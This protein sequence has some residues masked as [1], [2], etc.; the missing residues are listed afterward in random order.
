MPGPSRADVDAAA[1]MSGQDRQAMIEGMVAQLAARL[2]ASGGD[3]EEWLRLIR[4]YQVLGRTDD[5]KAAAE[6]ALDAFS[7]DPEAQARIRSIEAEIG[8]NQ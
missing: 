5:A 1:G 7:G 3:V 8:L 6:R 4:A 2:D